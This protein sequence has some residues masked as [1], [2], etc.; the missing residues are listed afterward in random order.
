MTVPASLGPASFHAA[1]EAARLAAG[2]QHYPAGALYVVATPIGNLD[3]ITAD[4]EVLIAE[5]EMVVEPLLSRHLSDADIVELGN[6]M[7]ATID[8]DIE[9]NVG[10]PKA[11]G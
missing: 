5:E 4:I 2:P 8:L 3:D 11:K 6:A 7:Q 9:R 10:A 1:L